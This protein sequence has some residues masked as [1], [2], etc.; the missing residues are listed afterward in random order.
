[1][2]TVLLDTTDLAEAEAALS[3]NY[4]KM[5]LSG[6]TAAS[7]PLRVKRSFVGSIGIDSIDYGREFSYAMDPLEQLV[8]CRVVSGRLEA[9]HPLEPSA[10]CQ[11]GDVYAFG[12]I[13]GV[14]YSGCV[15]AGHYDNLLI[16][17]GLLSKAA[18]EHLDTGA[19]VQLTGSVSVSRKAA[20]R[21]FEGI[22]YATRVAA[23]GEAETN[24][25]V[26]TGLEQ[27]LATMVIR[28]F[29]STVVYDTPRAVRHDGS[30]A[31]LRRATAFI[32]DHADA[33]I[34]LTDIAAEV[35][36]TPRALQYM[37]RK[38]R[39]CTPMEY[40]RRVRL[41]RA[42][43]DLVGGHHST[44]TVSEVARRWGFAHVGRFAVLYRQNYG[45]SPHVTLG[46]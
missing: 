36:L 42:H 3:A 31:L 20:Q 4:S 38:H 23:S 16:D 5:H 10:T 18:E 41:S 11:A 33:D 45:Q 32:D 19:R 21:L 35:Y 39:D 26:A 6:P 40:V 34:S 27:Y 46:S 13:E 22:D 9:G 7:S 12:A 29:P 30:P 14:P 28:T 44:T 8:V 2:S 24:P 15:D 1:M 25:L 43:L 17:R 37:F